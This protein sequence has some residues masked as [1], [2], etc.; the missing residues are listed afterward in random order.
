MPNLYPLNVEVNEK[1]IAKVVNLF[2]GAYKDIVGEI[3]TAS[4]F[5]VSNRKAI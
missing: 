3:S 5:G 2:K 4:N 1:S